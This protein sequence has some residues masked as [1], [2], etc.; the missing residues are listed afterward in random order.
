MWFE[1]LQFANVCVSRTHRWQKEN[2]QD[3]EELGNQGMKGSRVQSF[4]AFQ[5]DNKGWSPFQT[6]SH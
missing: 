2:F 5:L 6:W 4:S 1:Y 3:H